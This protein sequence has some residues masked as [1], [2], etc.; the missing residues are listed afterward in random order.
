MD[1]LDR[2]DRRILD[3]LAEQGRIS[4]VALAEKI[5][6]S[7]TPTLGRL[8]RLERSGIILG[9][10]AFVDHE[11]LDRGHVAFVQVSL[12]DTRTEALTAFNNAVRQTAEITDCHMIAGNFDYLLKVRSRDIND[13]RRILGEVISSLPHVSHTSTFVAMEMVKEQR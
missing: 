13:Y 5:G 7:K 11:R 4:V 6:L 1:D 3:I 9:Y 2:F 8:K 12:A 10:G